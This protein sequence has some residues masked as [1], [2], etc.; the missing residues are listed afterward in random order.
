MDMVDYWLDLINFSEK[1]GAH[2][3]LSPTGKI[4][5]DVENLRIKL[6][7][8]EWRETKKAMEDQDIVEI[9]D[10][11]ADLLYVV[12]GTAVAYGIPIDEVF[13][14]VHRSNMSKVGLDGIVR[15]DEY[16]KIMKPEGWKSPK[17]EIRKVLNIHIEGTKHE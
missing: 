17:E 3:E 12:F 9:A 7:E 5:E 14:E 15:R 6:I 13:R 16:G 4:P 2:V 1:F 10:G 11:L 8:E